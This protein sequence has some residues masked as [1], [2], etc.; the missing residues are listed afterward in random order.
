M[1][2]VSSTNARSRGFTLLEVLVAVVVLAIGLVALAALQ[3]SL[4]R[5]SAEAKVRARVAAMLST[6][7]DD[8][9]SGG[10]G[11]LL[12]EGTAAPLTSTTGDCDPATPDAADWMDCARVQAGV[13]SLTTNQ[14][15]TTWSGTA[16]FAAA[17]AAPTV[18]QFKR[19]TLTASWSDATGSTHQ[20]SLASD[21]SPLALT[22]NV[23][24]P[25]DDLTVGGVG[26][27]VRTTDPATLG[28][29]PIA[30]NTSSVSASSNPVPELV[31]RNNNKQVVG[32]KFT[33]LNYTPS[34][35][36]GV[37]IQKRFENEVIKCSC[38]YGAGGTNLPE[39]YRT[40]Q[41]PAV[42]GGQRYDVYKPSSASA[43]PGQTFDSGPNSGV[44]QSPLCQECCRDHHDNATT[45]VAKFD[46]ER[47]DGAT[48]KY[49][50]NGSNVLVPASTSG[51]RY[52]DA[53]RVIRVDGFWRTA[54]DM[55]S[56]QLGLL[57][58]ES[59]AN[60]AAKTGVPTDSA[61][62]A[63]TGF[64]KNYLK[65]YDGT[66]ATAPTNAQSLFDGTSGINV[67]ALVTIGAVSN[68]DYRYLHARGLYVD[69]LEDGARS[70]LADV[71]ADDGPAGKC[72][73]GS[74]V[75]DCVLPYLPF[76]A[77]NVTEIAKWLASNSS[78]L[79]VN[80]GNLLP[81]PSDPTQVPDPTQPSGSRTIGKAVGTSDNTATIRKSTS[82]IAVNG[83]LTG[84]NG[85]DPTDDADVAS[86]AQPF[87]VNG[88][89]NAGA[90]FDVRVSN[91]AGANPFVWFSV[92]T[93]ADRQC[94]KPANADYHCVTS[95]TV[96]LPQ[97]GSIRVGNYGVETTASG[98]IPNG[99]C[100]GQRQAITIDNWPVFRN[101]A[102]VG[103]S[104]NGAAGSI[105]G[106]ANDN[107][108]SEY[109]IIAFTTIP[110]N[111]L[112]SVSL[113]EQAGSPTYAAIASCT[114]NGGGN[115]I[116]TITWVSPYPWS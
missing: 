82:G 81:N 20:L 44:D 9:R 79:T 8:L 90:T 102:V 1:S 100:S 106:P 32:T 51:G 18:P 75:E 41:W 113:S 67:P 52:V 13:G 85:V 2:H 33:V 72:P 47:R 71:L 97:A 43:A 93:D 23:I 3:G 30:L 15:I 98:T 62:A 69:Y 110:A 56:R 76:T 103:A 37:V 4:T 28:V 89:Q 107:R 91:G 54:S 66:T 65:Q 94:L 5:N 92:S 73:A 61:I 83:V 115:Q 36:S 109:T 38:R 111:G 48:T 40:A 12:P 112:I 25:P 105:S 108:T 87:Q 50:L 77:V 96:T 114:T 24:P 58:T 70:K 14:T 80:S 26:P 7:M 99:K 46:P 35:N 31:G 16:N 34:S 101:Y 64:V 22:S 68:S 116:K 27:I 86:D 55:Y 53:C 10:Y 84:L 63:Y 49:D 95:S 29:I 74:N 42:W 11:N 45:G 60:V 17:P 57:Q 39:I 78:V 59:I 104:V 21:I 88:A 19:L 6:R